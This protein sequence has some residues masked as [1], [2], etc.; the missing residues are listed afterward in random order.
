LSYEGDSVVLS[1][2]T[3]LRAEMAGEYERVTVVPGAG[4][5]VLSARAERLHGGLDL[6][7]DSDSVAVLRLELP[8]RASLEMP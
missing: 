7:I 2:Q 8:T 4:L 3:E 5:G 1:L 6:S